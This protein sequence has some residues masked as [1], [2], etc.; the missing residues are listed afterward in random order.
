MTPYPISFQWVQLLLKLICHLC[1]NYSCREDVPIGNDLDQ[2]EIASAVKT[3]LQCSSVTAYSCDLCL[4]QSRFS[5]L[6]FCFILF[7]FFFN[8]AYGWYFGT[9]LFELELI[10]LVA[11]IGTEMFFMFFISLL[12]FRSNIWQV[13]WYIII[14]VRNW[15]VMWLWWARV[16]KMISSSGARF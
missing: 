2:E 6:C 16:D 5:S 11:L 13:F 7:G 4:Y 8:S 14:W 9:S 15:L 12:F 1:F 10:G 3:F